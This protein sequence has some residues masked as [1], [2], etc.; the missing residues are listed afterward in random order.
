[1]IFGSIFL[2]C[3]FEFELTRVKLAGFTTEKPY[4][5]GNDQ[6]GIQF[7][8]ELQKD[9]KG[10][11]EKDVILHKFKRVDL[12]ANIKKW[13]IKLI[14]A[15]PRLQE[16]H[17]PKLEKYTFNVPP[18]KNKATYQSYGDLYSYRNNY[19]YDYYQYDEMINKEIDD[20]ES[21]Y[22]KKG[23]KRGYEMAMRHKKLK[24][25][26]KKRLLYN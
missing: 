9:A 24:H 5:E 19:Y 22:F 25:N 3:C 16:P 11:D 20:L 2:I 4:G 23:F 15:H 7:A 14:N 1:M 26:H 17:Y 21:Y 6:I 12:I 8:T 13:G 10:N 18:K